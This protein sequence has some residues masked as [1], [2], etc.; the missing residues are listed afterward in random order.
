MVYAEEY[1]REKR[2]N[3]REVEEKRF[4]DQ[5]MRSEVTGKKDK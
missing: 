4:W 5:H 1:A 2:K 3:A